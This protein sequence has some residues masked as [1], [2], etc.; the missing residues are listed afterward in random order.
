MEATLRS[1]KGVT[2]TAE[3]L[4]QNGKQWKLQLIVVEQENE[5]EDDSYAGQSAR[6]IEH[7]FIETIVSRVQFRYFRFQ[8]CYQ[9]VT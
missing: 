3:H 5:H 9:I 6:E 2:L 4:Q 7:E 8:L 1:K